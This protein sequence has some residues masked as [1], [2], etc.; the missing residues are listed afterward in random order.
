M[1]EMDTVSFNRMEEGTKEDY[2]FLESLEAKALE[3]LTDRLLAMLAD[4][5][6][7]LQGYKV[8]RLEH[9]LQSASRAYRD[10]RDEDYV[11]MALLHDIGDGIAPMNHSSVAGAILRPYVSERLYWIVQHHGLFQMYYYAHH[12]GLNRNARDQFKDSPFYADTVE[13]C[14]KYDQN[15]FDPDYDSLPL[16]FFEPMVR[17]VFAKQAFGEAQRGAI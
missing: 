13:F 2:E 11:V 7:V 15:C 9:V 17:N 12:L 14:E 5:E 16:E 3:G 10:G 6:D 4:A 1:S 8:S